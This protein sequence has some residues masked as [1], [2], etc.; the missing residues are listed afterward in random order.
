MGYYGSAKERQLSQTW[1]RGV[2]K[3]IWCK[4]LE[5]VK[6]I[7]HVVRAD[8]VMSMEAKRGCPRKGPGIEQSTPKVVRRLIV[9]FECRLET[10]HYISKFNHFSSP[11]TIVCASITPQK[12]SAMPA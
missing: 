10:M 7:C 2:G 6:V 5:E 11:L 12:A 4:Y 8:V 1:N 3:A 9:W